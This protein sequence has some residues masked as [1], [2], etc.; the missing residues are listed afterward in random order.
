MVMT[1]VMLNVQSKPG[2]AEQAI[3]RFTD[4]APHIDLSA[5]GSCAAVRT[6]SDHLC[7]LSRALRHGLY[8]VL[9]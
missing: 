7:C 1:K 8:V 5:I 9:E 6:G 2:D 3:S 4:T